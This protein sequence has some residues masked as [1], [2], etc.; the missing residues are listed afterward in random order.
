MESIIWYVEGEL[1]IP[2]FHKAYLRRIMR[3]QHPS[4]TGSIQCIARCTDV[5]EDSLAHETVIPKTSV[6]SRVYHINTVYKE[7]CDGSS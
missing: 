4:E 5:W 2:L 1:I 7:N 6:R 3:L